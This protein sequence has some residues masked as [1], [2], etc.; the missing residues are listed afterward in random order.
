MTT[1]EHDYK[2]VLLAERDG[3]CLSLY[4]PTHRS[5][6]D[7]QQDPIRFG[8]LVKELSQSLAR[9][10]SDQ[11][12]AA[13]LRP[14][15]ELAE[16]SQFWKHTLDGIAVFAT[17][18]VFKIYNLQRSVPERAIVAESF[19]TKPLVR[20]LQSSDRY[21]ILGL[22]RRSATLF[23]GNR[24]AVDVMPTDD[25]FP[26]SIEAVT[27]TFAGEPERTKRSHG[28]SGTGKITRHG[29]DVRQDL[30]DNETQQFFRAVAEAVTRNY[31]RPTGMPLLLAAL[32]EHHHLFREVSDNPL[33]MAQAIDV[34]PASVSLE[35]L[36]ARAWDIVLPTYLE[37]LDHLVERF[38]AAAAT[39][40]GSADLSE[41][42]K[43]AVAGRIETLLLD[44]DRV[45]PG[46]VN[47]KT[48]FIEF[49]RLEDPSVDDVLDDLS[50]RTIK[51]GGEVVIV[52]PE[53]MPSDTGLAAIYRF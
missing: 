28:P 42:G 30:A 1:L 20:V 50:E 9:Q 17:A 29:T 43:A 15:V 7:R 22:N 45:V 35:D 6:P 41:I 32:P 2:S 14:F 16:D 46:H 19:H 34:D 27:G 8:N 39:E 40:R 13:L 51:T 53:R 49:A 4:Q 23:E 38:E 44:A 48:G 52:P 24:F 25:R 5:F 18:D 11:D 10:Y 12:S 3:P 26:A 33:L 31:S 37:R 36:R 47:A 21:H